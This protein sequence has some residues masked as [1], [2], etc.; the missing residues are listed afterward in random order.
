MEVEVCVR[1]L[2]FPSYF[3]CTCP[4]LVW[5]G[6]LGIGENG[7]VGLEIRKLSLEVK[8]IL[9]LLEL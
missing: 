6:G 3:I 9:L 4:T 5:T 1:G 8:S 7:G 2:L